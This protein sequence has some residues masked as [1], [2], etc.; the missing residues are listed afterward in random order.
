[1]PYTGDQLKAERL[2]RKVSRSRLARFMEVDSNT[3]YRWETG[4]IALPKYAEI[5]YFSYFEKYNKQP[6]EVES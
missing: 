1:M 4:R 5:S 6:H 3:L 2:R